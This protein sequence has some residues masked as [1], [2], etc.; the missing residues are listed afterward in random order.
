[1]L[2]CY[3]KSK[4]VGLAMDLF[5]RLR[6]HHKASSFTFSILISAVAKSGDTSSAEKLLVLAV[7]ELG[8]EGCPV[9]VYQV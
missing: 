9:M 7:K 8:A 3:T 1:M 6:R 2:D 4:R 5:K